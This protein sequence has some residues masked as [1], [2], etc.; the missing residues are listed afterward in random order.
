MADKKISELNSAS[1]PL[2]GTEVVPIVQGSE[3]K[4]VSVSEFKDVLEF[5]NLASFPL[6]G[7]NGKIYVALDTNLQYRWSGSAY[8][9]IGSGGTSKRTY[10]LTFSIAI[11]NVSDLVNWYS[12]SDAFLTKYAKTYASKTYITDANDFADDRNFNFN[13]IIPFNCKLKNVF[14]D[15]QANTNM[16]SWRLAVRSFDL[17]DN[18]DGLASST[19]VT[20]SKIIAIKDITSIA[21]NTNKRRYKFDAADMDLTHTITEMSC[22]KIYL[23]GLTGGGYV[24]FN[25]TLEFEE[26]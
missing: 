25:T 3:T 19:D 17:P 9:Q 11:T 6:T 5:A 24:N 21:F 15:F 8:V 26:I 22:V 2:A 13:E 1:L 7:E 12:E 14:I 18:Y 10:F 23:L 16:S 20:N 4:K